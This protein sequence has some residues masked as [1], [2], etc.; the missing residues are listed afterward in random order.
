MDFIVA[1]DSWLTAGPRRYRC[2]LGRNG[3]TTAKTEGDGATPAGA[4]PLR[5]LLFRA[6]RYADPESKLPK[7]AIA[8]NDGWCDTPSDPA[9]NRPVTLPYGASAE[10]LWRDDGLY[11]LVVVLG[12][13]DDPARPGKGSAIFLHCAAPGMTPTE[14]CVALKAAD[15]IVLLRDCGPGDRLVVNPPGPCAGRR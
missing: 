6:D 2:A 9:Y 5:R 10:Q 3:I 14:G 7:Q 12:Y 13:N 4:W 11:D 15:L 8:Q 1:P